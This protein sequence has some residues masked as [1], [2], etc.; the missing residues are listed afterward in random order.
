MILRLRLAAHQCGKACLT[1]SQLFK[2]GTVTFLFQ[3]INYSAADQAIDETQ[4][5]SRLLL[6]VTDHVQMI[7][8]DHVSQ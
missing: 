4:N 2:R 7:R 8:H 1:V 3:K 5:H 6:T